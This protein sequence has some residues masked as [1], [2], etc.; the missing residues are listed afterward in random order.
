MD[1]QGAGLARSTGSLEH[2][3]TLHERFQH[4]RDQ[5]GG[6]DRL[7]DGLRMQRGISVQLR[8]ERTLERQIV[9][10]CRDRYRRSRVFC[11]GFD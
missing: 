2:S 4:V 10:G 1:D 8:L 3:I 7:A 6:V 9:I 5:R 11:S